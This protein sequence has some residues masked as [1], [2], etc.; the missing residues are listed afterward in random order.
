MSKWILWFC[1]IACTVAI[2][3]FWFWFLMFTVPVRGDTT[4]WQTSMHHCVWLNSNSEIKWKLRKVF[5]VVLSLRWK[6]HRKVMALAPCYCSI[7]ANT[8]SISKAHRCFLSFF[9]VFLWGAA[10]N[11]F[12][13][14]FVKTEMKLTGN[15]ILTENSLYWIPA[16]GMSEVSELK[17]EW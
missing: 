10:W 1:C 17:S 16:R 7:C 3:S 11:S 9:F 6:C 8:F 4:S 2:S 13:S 14:A 15:G 5:S 12:F